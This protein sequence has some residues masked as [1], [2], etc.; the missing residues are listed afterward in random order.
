VPEQ[1]FRRSTI[2]V[3][4][5]LNYSELPPTHDAEGRSFVLGN[6]GRGWLIRSAGFFPNHLAGVLIISQPQEDRMAQAII[7]GPFGKFYLANNDWVNP[8]EPFH[9]GGG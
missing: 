7:P 8:I 3:R 9:F 1:I 6:V 4:T 2:Q 5:N